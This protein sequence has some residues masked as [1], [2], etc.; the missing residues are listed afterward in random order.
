MF[1]YDQSIPK[2]HVY[3]K[4]FDK[5][6][7]HFDKNLDSGNSEWKYGPMERKQP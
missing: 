5:K 3:P 6:K 7:S 4:F 2:V 1:A